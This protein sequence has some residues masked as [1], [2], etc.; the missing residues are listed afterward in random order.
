MEGGE[1]TARRDS[2]YDPVAGAVTSNVQVGVYVRGMEPVQDKRAVP[3]NGCVNTQCFL[4]WYVSS[5]P[6]R[7][8]MS[9]HCSDFSDT[10]LS[11]IEDSFL[12]QSYAKQEQ[13]DAIRNI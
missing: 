8:L 3:L 7:Y 1:L 5:M 6:H 4:N 11:R 9:R 10:R 12:L 13:G 2:I